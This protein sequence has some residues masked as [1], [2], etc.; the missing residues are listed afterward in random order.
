MSELF[1]DILVIWFVSGIVG[2]TYLSVVIF[3]FI[4]IKFTRKFVVKYFERK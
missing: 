2:G 1:I 3:A 4:V